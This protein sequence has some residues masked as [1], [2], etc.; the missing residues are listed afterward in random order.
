[1]CLMGFFVMIQCAH[2]R[3]CAEPEQSEATLRWQ[4]QE[5]SW[6]HR[7]LS[8]LPLP[9]SLGSV[10]TLP[11]YQTGVWDI[12]GLSARN[13]VAVGGTVGGLS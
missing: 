10:Q 1:M 3:L 2:K 6:S 9:N 7:V 12:L 8:C 5:L 11:I 13:C 4:W